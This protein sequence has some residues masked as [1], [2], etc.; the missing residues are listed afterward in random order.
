MLRDDAISEIKFGLGRITT[1]D[2][3]SNIAS[4]LR[5]AQRLSE[6]MVESL[7]W[8]L[9][10]YYDYSIAV[11]ATSLT[12]ESDFLIE[13]RMER[14][15]SPLLC[16]RNG[17]VVAYIEKIDQQDLYADWLTATSTDI[18]KAYTLYGTSLFFGP[19]AASAYTLRHFY[20]KK[21]TTLTNNIENLWLRE[22]P[23]LLIG[24]AGARLAVDL[25]YP[26]AAGKFNSIYVS[27]KTSLDSKNFHRRYSGR[28]ISYGD[29]L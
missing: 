21:D 17:V 25:E 4:A 28:Q 16:I 26:E 11:G 9:E 23:D 27:A 5:Q 7:P 2:L 20:Y 3:D 29:A 24:L 14:A 6:Q 13:R 12:L 8:F 22:A 15:E 10:T 19:P 18:P 1:T